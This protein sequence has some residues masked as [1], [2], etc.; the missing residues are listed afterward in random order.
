M[1]VALDFEKPIIEL[2]KKIA[3]L[4]ILSE[5]GNQNL[6]EEIRR[7]EIQVKHL[8]KEV[9]DNLD[10]WQITQL[11]RHPQRPYFLDYVENIFDEFI[12]LHGDR[13]Y[14]DDPAIVAG[15]ARVGDLNL[16]IIGH[17]K[18]RTTQQKVYRNFGMPHPEGYR[19]A[20]R[21]LRKAAQFKLPIITF[22]DTPGAYPGIDAEERGQSEA[23]ARSLLEI[24]RVRTPTVSVVIG[25]GG[26]G[27]ALALGVT[28]RIVMMQYSIYSVISPE[29]CASILW[30][31]TSKSKQAASALKMGAKAVYDLGIVDEVVQEP[32]GGA[33]RDHEKAA[34]LLKRELIKQVQQIKNM[35]IDKLLKLRY[36]KFRKI[37]FIR[38]F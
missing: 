1:E 14:M 11:A 9:F 20:Q 27:G 13:L 26:S 10:P 24:S 19:K 8:T 28:D 3:E 16:M 15:L 6:Y 36:Q 30:S 7:L 32:L 25:E 37:S 34:R 35:N 17:Q 33:H 2:E 5:Q 38:E 31:D 4:K 12:E 23:I 21:L 22:I 29:S 18:G